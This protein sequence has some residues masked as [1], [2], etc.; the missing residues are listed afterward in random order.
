MGLALYRYR[1]N[2]RSHYV[3]DVKM[4]IIATIIIT[5]I[6]VIISLAFGYFLGITR[7]RNE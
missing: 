6:V 3:L 5:F 1:S 4:T 7:N 2:S